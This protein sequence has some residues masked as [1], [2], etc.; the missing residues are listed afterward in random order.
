MVLLTSRGS[1]APKIFLI[2]P[3]ITHCFYF[4]A[5]KEFGGRLR[6]RRDQYQS[7]FWGPQPSIS[8]WR[9]RPTTSSGGQELSFNHRPPPLQKKILHPGWGMAFSLT[10]KGHC[11]VWWI[12]RRGTFKSLKFWKKF[13]KF[14]SC[15]V[16][17]ESILL[18]KCEQ[19][20]TLEIFRNFRI[21]LKSKG[22]IF[23]KVRIKANT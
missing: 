19:K 22:L 4:P 23:K 20:R 3:P 14:Q 2:V 18:L 12:G 16:L 15:L 9:E 5:S 13:L 10:C 11:K 1:F 8:Q 21:L 6:T 17:P 7:N